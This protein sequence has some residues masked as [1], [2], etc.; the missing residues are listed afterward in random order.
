[1]PTTSILQTIH[2][3]VHLGPYTCMEIIF[4]NH[5]VLN[6][7]NKRPFGQL[8]KNNSRIIINKAPKKGLAQMVVA[9]NPVFNFAFDFPIPPMRNFTR[10][11]CCTCPDP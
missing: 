10:G 3:F 5:I 6:S 4:A 7:Q 2:D 11:P 9:D 1:M 8:H